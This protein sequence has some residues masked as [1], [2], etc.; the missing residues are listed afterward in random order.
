MKRRLREFVSRFEVD[1]LELKDCLR[2]FPIF[3]ILSNDVFEFDRYYGIL[4]DD[5]F[6]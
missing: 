1:E 4:P 5:P 6:V 3:V 2:C